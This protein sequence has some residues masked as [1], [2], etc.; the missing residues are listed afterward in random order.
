[1]SST[2][3]RA[4]P[5]SEICLELTKL[6]GGA[7]T[8]EQY[9]AAYRTWAGNRVKEGLERARA[10]GSRL[11]RPLGS[12]MSIPTE[13]QGKTLDVAARYGVSRSTV[14]RWRRYRSAP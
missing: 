3:P 9:I 14:K 12:G 8:A 7:L 10:R 13:L 6:L 11:G 1:M 2:Q 4:R 5:F